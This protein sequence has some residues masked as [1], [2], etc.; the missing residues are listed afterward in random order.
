MMSKKNKVVRIAFLKGYNSVTEGLK[1]QNCQMG[2]SM[3]QDTLLRGSTEAA[4]PLLFSLEPSQMFYIFLLSQIS[5]AK[6]V[7]QYI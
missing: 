6:Q 7:L 1:Q 3:Y 5:Y 2:I 4:L